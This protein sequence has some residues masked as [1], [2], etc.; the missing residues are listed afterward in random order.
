MSLTEVT[1]DELL[2]DTPTPP[3][4]SDD[5]SAWLPSP[6]THARS[7]TPRSN[8]QPNAT[9]DQHNSRRIPM[10]N[11]RCP[12]CNEPIEDARSIGPVTLVLEPCGHQV[13]DH[14]YSDL[15]GEAADPGFS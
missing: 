11:P 12:A 5:G 2:Y 15:L 4:Y 14:L 13:D 8:D 10:T 6:T 1:T 9:F 3:R 7:H